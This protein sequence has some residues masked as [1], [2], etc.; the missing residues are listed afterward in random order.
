MIRK[1]YSIS[2]LLLFIACGKKEVIDPNAE[3][4]I[5]VETMP[6]TILSPNELI[7]KGT[8]KLLNREEVVDKG[9]ILYDLSTQPN[10]PVEI[11]MGKN[12]SQGET[13]EYNYQTS[14]KLQVGQPFGYACYVKTQKAYYKGDMVPFS[15]DLITIDSPEK[16]FVT[17]GDDVVIKGNFEQMD[18]TYYLTLGTQSI[19]QIDY[20]LGNNLGELTF[21]LPTKGLQHG[22]VLDLILHTKMPNGNTQYQ[23]KLV[24]IEVL[25]K[26]DLPPS[27]EIHYNDPLPISG[28]GFPTQHY[29]K[30]NVLI[31]GKSFPLYSGLLLSDFGP[32]TGTSIKWAIDYG[33]NNIVDFPEPLIMK[34]P[35]G[36][37]LKLSQTTIH[38]YEYLSVTGL[39]YKTYFNTVIDKITVGSYTA[40]IRS[41]RE[42]QLTIAIDDLPAGQYPVKLYSP[43]YNIQSQE[44]FR[45]KPLEVSTAPKSEAYP[46]EVI[47]LAGSFIQNH[48]YVVRYGS[49]IEKWHTSNTPNELQI[50]V[51]RIPASDYRIQVGYANA[52]G[53][54]YRGG[55]TF[56]L[57][58]H[59]SIVEEVT[60][61][62]IKAGE[63]LT[64][65][66]KGLLDIKY[67]L[68]GNH[69]VF[70]LSADNSTILVRIPYTILPGQY[71]ITLY[72]D[73][74]W[75]GLKTNTTLDIL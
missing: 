74:L 61:L 13:F 48:S 41:V 23:R 49:D 7:F 30:L 40:D 47:T 58:V 43:M 32:F 64:I 36:A 54:N 70:P 22:E 6:I 16:R 71:D 56:P 38:P 11:S 55:I 69:T 75:N 1:I 57:K 35:D 31:N 51:P 19:Q 2:I 14:E 10:I 33:H 24:E 59:E 37:D 15:V 12:A 34:V 25:A 17:I 73:H 52:T 63:T 3:P 21:S 72:T 44:Q 45:V 5:E 20:R 66:G 27:Y 67:I 42:Q 53:H 50:Q 65:K 28:I 4:S 18:E 46:H 29:D 62:K 26:I 68:F 9:F 8:I 39:N 60:P